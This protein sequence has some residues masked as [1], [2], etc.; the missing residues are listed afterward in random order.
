MQLSTK[1][2]LSCSHFGWLTAQSDT[3]NLWR[4]R[5]VV[6]SRFTASTQ[7]VSWWGP[8][9][10]C[11]EC[12]HAL[13]VADLIRAWEQFSGL[14]SSVLKG[15]ASSVYETGCTPYVLQV[16]RKT[17]MVQDNAFFIMVWECERC[18]D[19][20]EHTFYEH[21]PCRWDH[22]SSLTTPHCMYTRWHHRS[23]LTT[24]HCMYT[25]WHHRSSLTTPHCM[26]TRW[27]HRSSLTTPHCMY[28]H[29]VTSWSQLSTTRR[30]SILKVTS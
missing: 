13:C 16:L 29:K 24:P 18:R 3:W 25:R 1:E 12:L 21:T 27:D 6:L 4:K 5:S 7:P 14:N 22:R 10:S 23:S 15:V 20:T 17:V 19:N 30:M 28:I 11:T 26:Y 8:R 2:F 9:C